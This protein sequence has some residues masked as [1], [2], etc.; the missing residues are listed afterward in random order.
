MQAD[1]K[2]CLRDILSECRGSPVQQLLEIEKYASTV[3]KSF[4]WAANLKC[5][6]TVDKGRKRRRVEDGQYVEKDSQRVLQRKVMPKHHDAYVAVSYC[7]D[8]SMY[9]DPVNGGYNISTADGRWLTNSVRDIVLDRVVAYARYQEVQ[10]IWIDQQCTNQ[11]DP[12]EQELAI[13]SMDLVY[14]NSRYPLGVLMVPI[15][16][17]GRLDLLANL[18]RGHFVEPYDDINC[19]SLKRTVAPEKVN[20]VLDLLC[21]ITSDPW[22]TRGWVF[23]EE[24][25]SST[26]MDLLIPHD[27]SLER[28]NYTNVFGDMDN[29]LL[30][31]SNDFRTEATLFCLAC[32]N[33]GDFEWQA[34]R[35]ICKRILKIAG[36]YNIMLR[37]S[38]DVEGD[39]TCKS[40]S[41]II[42]AD[43][44]LRNIKVEPDILA[45]AANCC[46]YPVRLNTKALKDNPYSLSLCIIALYL[47]NGEILLNDDDDKVDLTGNMFDILKHQSLIVEAPVEKRELTFTKYCRFVDVKFSLDGIIT[48]GHVW[49]LYRRLD[50]RVIPFDRSEPT[51]R[52]LSQEQYILQQLVSELR[53]EEYEPLAVYIEDYL[54]TENQNSRDRSMFFKKR[55]ADEVVQTIIDGGT[56]HLGALLSDDYSPYRG[57]FIGDTAGEQGPRESYAFTA[58]RQGNLS[59]DVFRERDIDQFVSLEVNRLS[60]SKI[61]TQTLTIKRWMNGLC[62]FNGL[63]KRDVIFPWPAFLKGNS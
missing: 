48:T 52:W 28:G 22:W 40:L 32:L 5:L 41:S 38:P 4:E 61:G 59:D 58:W 57:I 2:R 1:T 47:L 43:I 10:A 42:I 39:G 49:T 55:M 50:T 9:E 44:G 12:E 63:P 54:S 7:W 31:Q 18:L 6:Y 19:P 27:P 3:E 56:L 62:F 16:T 46:E 36:K 53:K 33:N 13:Q 15:L 34:G 60:Y 8:P 51:N 45:I 37:Y 14:R 25:R 20:E 17:Q 24:Y 23:Q 30:V 11:N 29:E 35:M 21:H 26:N